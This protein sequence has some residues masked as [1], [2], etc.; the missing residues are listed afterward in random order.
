MHLVYKSWPGFLR[1][2]PHIIYA[3]LYITSLDS[4]L[5]LSQASHV[6]SK[7]NQG[8]GMYTPI[9]SKDPVYTLE[10][11][12]TGLQLGQREGCYHLQD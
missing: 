7:S 11:C 9:Q 12:M 10:M 5:L 3:S 1:L 4:S 6:L 2:S 8:N